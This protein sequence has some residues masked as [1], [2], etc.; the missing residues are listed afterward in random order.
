MTIKVDVFAFGVVLMELITGRK[1]L[2]ETLPEDRTNLITWF[3]KFMT[4]KDGIRNL[5]DPCLVPDEETFESICKV[6]EL[7]GYCTAREPNQRPDMG[8]AVN[9]LAPLVE[10]WK[11]TTDDEDYSIDDYLHMSLPQA[12]QR[13]QE[14]S[15]AMTSDFFNTHSHTAR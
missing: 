1:S 12:L 15:S 10:Q 2:D 9:V 4:S 5:V 6:A 7:A 14:N 3:K 13:W 8:H 11:P